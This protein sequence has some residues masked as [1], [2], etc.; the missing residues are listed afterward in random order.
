MNSDDEQYAK[1]LESKTSSY[2]TDEKIEI[3]VSDASADKLPGTAPPTDHPQALRVTS[4]KEAREG[5]LTGIHLS[6]FTI[7]SSQGS[8]RIP[9]IVINSPENRE[10][11]GGNGV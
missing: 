3:D 10:N 8:L 7:P 1:F 5:R 6:R 4:V 11:S 9:S 2:L